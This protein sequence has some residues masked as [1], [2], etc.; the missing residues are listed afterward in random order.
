MAGAFNSLSQNL[1]YCTY[2]AH[3]HAQIDLVTFLGKTQH[4][5]PQHLNTFRKLEVQ[6]AIHCATEPYALM[7]FCQDLGRKETQ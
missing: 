4:S 7:H 2:V 6:H 5:N 1:K 3:L